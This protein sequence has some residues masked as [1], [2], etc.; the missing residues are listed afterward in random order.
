MPAVARKDGRDTVASPDGSGFCCSSPSTQKTAAG[1]DDVFINNIGAVRLRDAMI[2]HPFPGPCC[3]PHAPTL[4]SSS[5]TVFVNGRGLGR[6]NDD[7]SAHVISSG[8]SNV[9]AGG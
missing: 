9:F 8:S 4:S 6:Q 7:Y 3:A 2:V 5:T 1:S